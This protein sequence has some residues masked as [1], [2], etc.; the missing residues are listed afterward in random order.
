MAEKQPDWA[1]LLAKAWVNQIREVFRNKGYD[2]SPSK[3]IV[4]QTATA[5]MKPIDDAFNQG[6]AYDTPDYVMREVLKQ[7]IWDFSVAKNHQDNLAINNLLLDDDGKLRSWND[8]KRETRKVVGRSNRYLKTEYNTVVAGAQMSRLWMDIQRDKELFPFARFSVTE[9]GRTS[10]IC[11]PLAGVVVSVDDPMLAYYFPPNHFNCRTTVVKLRK[12]PETKE[13]TPPEIPE[14][15]QNNVGDT[16]EIF[17]KD[18]EYIKNTPKDVLDYGRQY[19][20]EQ[21]RE[22]RY[23]EIVFTSQKVGQGVF[24]IFK[25]GKQFKSEFEK[26][27]K[28]LRILAQNGEEVR[29]LPVIEDGLTNPDGY[30]ISSQRYM[31][32]KVPE[33]NNGKN[34]MQGALKQA[35]RQ[36]AEELVIHLLKK[37][38]SYRKMY[39]ALRYSVLKNRNKNVE[40]V[41]VIFPDNS[42]RTYGIEK[43]RQKIKKAQN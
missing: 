11:Q 38:D 37:P 24:G 29:L 36:E 19:Y 18:N 25:N 43:I 12:G 34:I 31:D 26:N 40:V 27:K 13:Y 30:N 28:A 35:S 2:G 7:N 5:L 22:D 1:D 15:F 33:G 21:R 42:I 14:A 4:T 17:T 8:F 23:K 6:I 20:F 16:G 41:T 32:V 39:E 3:P 10:E 9:D